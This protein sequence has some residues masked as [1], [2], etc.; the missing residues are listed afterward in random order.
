MSAAS[1]LECLPLMAVCGGMCVSWHALDS[2]CASS[3]RMVVA[4]VVAA[5]LRAQ[6]LRGCAGQSCKWFVTNLHRL[7]RNA[8]TVGADDALLSAA[9]PGREL[10]LL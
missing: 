9:W 1:I 3:G 7:L 4:P 5:V 6:L 2:Q 8:V 10:R